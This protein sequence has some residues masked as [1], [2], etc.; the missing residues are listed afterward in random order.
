LKK[1]GAK[2][3]KRKAQKVE[4]ASTKAKKRY[5]SKKSK[6]RHLHL[7]DSESES[8][9]ESQLCDDDELDDVDITE[10]SELCLVCGEFGQDNEIWYRCVICSKWAH[11]DCSGW[12]SPV[13]YTCDMCVKIQKK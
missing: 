8:W 3:G 6:I 4:Q 12:D 10:D 11:E 5:L 2:P 7:D 13:G 1:S 9:D